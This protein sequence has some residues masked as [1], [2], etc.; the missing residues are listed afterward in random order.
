M[1]RIAIIGGG[2]SG[3]SAAYALQKHVYRAAEIDYVL[4]E[5]GPHFG[6]VIHSERVNDFL[7]EAGPDSFLTEKPWAAELCRELGLGDQLIASSD[8]ER[9]TYI[10]VNGRLVP[11]PEGLMFMVPTDLAATFLS[12]LFSW[13]TKLRMIRE[14]FYRPS[15]D[16]PESTVAE[17]VERH[18]G[19]EMVERVAD[20]LV[21][22]VYGGGADELS[23]SS[24]LAR[25]VEIEVRQGSLGRAMVASRKL[26]SLSAEQGFAGQPRAAV[27]TR[28]L[29][30]SLKGGMQTMT[31][32]MLAQIPESA[33]RMN[34]PVAAVTPE[35]GKWLV[36]SRGRTEEFDAVIIATPA[37][38]A[39][40]LLR[41]DVP[42]LSSEL[43]AIRY[44]SS[45]TVA[46][47]YDEKTLASLPAGFGF[48]V[49]RTENKRILACTF[50]HNKFPNRAPSDSA[51]LRCF[52][53]GSRDEEILQSPDAEIVAT[54]RRELEEILGF[55]TE[56][57][58]VKI[59]KWRKAMAQYG[60][61]HKTRVELVRKAISSM[62]GLSLAGN[63]YNGIGIPDCVRS[64]SE[65]AAKI[66]VD[67]AI[68]QPRAQFA[69]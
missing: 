22:G 7:I 40:E 55:T 36:A 45:V 15:L 66:L 61:G 11:L 34:T 51:L 26:Q 2:V 17:F 27:P 10:F 28:S 13:P 23:A 25:F 32:A 4:F 33:R 52:L 59:Y 49:P 30:T 29:F 35:S 63:A 37:Y 54:V 31:D 20:P 69:R 1:K 38:T 64:G 67:L 43:E 60:V 48:L 19:R 12:P 39:A 42:Q 3:L 8:A 56:P 41:N 21:V 46:L 9:R 65:A 50:V 58:F 53:G 18:Y 5:A 24:V 44:S 16:V 14:W 6:G 62:P 68:V 47:A 57:S